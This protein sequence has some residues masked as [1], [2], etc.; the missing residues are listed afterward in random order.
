MLEENQFLCLL[1]LEDSAGQIPPAPL[2]LPLPAQSGS[3]SS[4][5]KLQPSVHSS[6]SVTALTSSHTSSLSLG[7]HLLLFSKDDNSLVDCINWCRRGVKFTRWGE[8]RD[9]AVLSCL[10]RAPC[11][12]THPSHRRSTG[13]LGLPSLARLLLDLCARLSSP[14]G[15]R[16]STHRSFPG[17]GDGEGDGDGEGVRERSGSHRDVQED[18]GWDVSVLGLPR[19]FSP[20]F[21]E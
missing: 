2:P 8:K 1:S 5:S 17:E 9:S 4:H 16:W 7:S 15:S 20:E 11:L 18:A 21:T 3:F 19:D 13:S 12:L 10:C 14:S 6:P